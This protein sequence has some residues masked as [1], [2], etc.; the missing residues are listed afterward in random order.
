MIQFELPQ[1]N[2]SI[3]KVIGV[4]GGGSNAVNHMFR[5]QIKGVEFLVCNTDRQALEESPI[6]GK[7]HLGK[8]KTKGLGAGSIPEIGKS[9]AMESEEEIRKA[10]SSNTEMVFITAGLG[11]GT[12]TGG[13]P[14]IASIAREMGIL[15]VGIVTMPF[16]FEGK[17]RKMQAE[18]GLEELKKHVDSLLVICNDKLRELY[19]SLKMKEAFARA[20]DV[21]ANAARG[22]AELISNHMHINVDFNDVKTVMKDSGLA[23]M[24]TAMA[25]GEDRA[26]KAVKDAL[27]SPLLND[28]DIVGARHVLLNVMSGS[29]DISMD[30]FSAIMDYIYEASGGTAD[31]IHGYGT[32]PSL[33]DSVSIT[34]VAT[35]FQPSS[36][37]SSLEPAKVHSLTVGEQKSE[38]ISSPLKDTEE[39]MK[40]VSV[41]EEKEIASENVKEDMV[42]QISKEEAEDK[43]EMKVYSLDDE[44]I[45]DT[46]KNENSSQNEDT[47]TVIHSQRDNLNRV[48]DR[49]KELRKNAAALLNPENISKYEKEPAYVRQNIMTDQTPYSEEE[50]QSQFTIDEEDGKPKIKPN[51]SFLHGQPS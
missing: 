13:A 41:V 8:T 18:Q 30:E 21:L 27:T 10:L 22:I 29:D 7:I 49:I 43:N 26:M 12:G 25:S 2:P 42:L 35:G 45:E 3:I 44:D 1:E 51:N 31:I 5:M 36:S 40:L 4:G 14:V 28:N 34:L 33:G 17:K 6:P 20:D 38:N 37:T 50:K 24:G 48:M 47:T 11:G 9:A 23:L 32:D 16:A 46:K 15:T 19:G 39:D